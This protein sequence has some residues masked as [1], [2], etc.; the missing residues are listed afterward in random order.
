MQGSI[1]D[2]GTENAGTGEKWR[3]DDDEMAMALHQASAVFEQVLRMRWAI[4]PGRLF[5]AA[6]Q[7]AAGLRWE[8]DTVTAHVP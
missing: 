8:F 1:G 3:L 6:V 5:C 2:A 4:P 7:S